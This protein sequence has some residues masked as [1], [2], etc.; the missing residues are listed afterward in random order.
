MVG[1]EL[2]IFGFLCAGV[3]GLWQ[4][5]KLR[6]IA[7]W[8]VAFLVTYFVFQICQAY[9]ATDE[10]SVGNLLVLVKSGVIAVIAGFL[11]RLIIGF[12]WN[13]KR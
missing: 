10:T 8:L 5:K 13:R 2:M 1:T 3:L 6:K 11:A 4:L 9:F 7:L 12:V